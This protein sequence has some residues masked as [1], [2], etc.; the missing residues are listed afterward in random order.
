[1]KINAQLRLARSQDMAAC[2]KIL[3][4]W[5]DETEWLPRLHSHE[6]VV[7]HYQTVVASERRSFVVASG[8]RIAGMM[9]L[10]TDHLV[11][12]LYVGAAFRRQGVGHML[13]DC[14]KRECGSDVSLW[15]FQK[16]VAAQQF[17]LHEGFVEINRTDGDN[18]EGLPD[19]LLEWRA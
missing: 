14:A 7:K 5:I 18:E 6:E 12:A 4:D 8:S 13:L 1:M 10:G 15:T 17:Y 2:A 11:T 3:N 19:M 9:A 16:N